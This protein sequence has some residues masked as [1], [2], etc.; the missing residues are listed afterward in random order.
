MI[1]HCSITPVHSQSNCCL[2]LPSPNICAIASHQDVKYRLPLSLLPL[3]MRMFFE[4][5][6]RRFEVE[7]IWNWRD[8]L[9]GSYRYDECVGGCD[10][11][12]Y[13]LALKKGEKNITLKWR[14]RVTITL[15]RDKL[16]LSTT[17]SL[18]SPPVLSFCL[19]TSTVGTSYG[20]CGCRATFD[21]FQVSVDYHPIKV[22]NFGAGTQVPSSCP[23]FCR[24]FNIYTDFVLPISTYLV[25]SS[26]CSEIP[27]DQ[28]GAD[29]G[30]PDLGW[31]EVSAPS[32]YCLSP[33]R[34]A[35]T[36]HSNVY[37]SLW[38]G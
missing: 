23:T 20:Y 13:G 2:F 28:V 24:Y 32:H 19:N 11:T 31:L 12:T 15:N 29:Q 16:K 4:R 10:T 35:T 6:G 1:R 27:L 7:V 36:R 33:P 18:L 30:C 3:N 17:S 38:N 34:T 26:K 5:C 14:E 21:P 37:W 25:P 22:P 9:F 8:C